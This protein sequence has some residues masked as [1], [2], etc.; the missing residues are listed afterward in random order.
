VPID[1]SSLPKVVLHDH[2]D[3]GLRPSTVLDLA[4]QIGYGGLPT[5][6]P[7]ELATWF[8]QSGAPSL[9]AY[10]G[11]FQHTVAVMGT[12]EALERVAYEA[13]EDLAS[14]GVVYAEVRFAPS[15][16]RS[17]SMDR[18]TVVD[19]VIR[20]LEAGERDHGIITRCILDA[21]R[22]DDDSAE[23]ASL[24]VEVGGRV[25]AF[26][27]AGPEAGNP[28]SAHAE[29]CRIAV[30]G[31][32][33][34]TIHAG[35]GDGVESIADALSCGAERIGH[36]VRI[37]EDTAVRDGAITGMGPVASRVRG[38]GIALEVC[39]R[40]NLDT[41]MYPTAQDHPV[42]LLHRAGMPV[43]LNTDNRLMSRT[44]MSRE[45]GLVVEHHGFA[46]SDLEA[47]TLR[48]A[49]AAFCDEDARRSV[50]RRIEA[51]Y[52]R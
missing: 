15:L 38:E 49:E 6:D 31:G 3:G 36:G 43:T 32:I 39:P 24:A 28:A 14:D 51:G 12:P 20:G 13:A 46:I 37:I 44:S 4:D 45:F 22:Q 52:A 48:A 10:L 50:R 33:R 21:M 42:G 29:A 30:D 11:A 8:D 2:L 25:V 16:H 5:S 7:D 17:D 47:V 35:E 40:S 26:D 9:E 34:L 27:L 41:H 18:R 23:I 19:A 1:I